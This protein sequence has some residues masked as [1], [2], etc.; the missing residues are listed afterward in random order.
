MAWDGVSIWGGLEQ[1]AEVLSYGGCGSIRAGEWAASGG[2]SCKQ[3]KSFSSLGVLLGLFFVYFWLSASYL[4]VNFRCSVH[5]PGPK[6]A[7]S[8]EGE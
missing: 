8:E 6:G 4:Q 7:A 3:K 2:V 1:S 5:L